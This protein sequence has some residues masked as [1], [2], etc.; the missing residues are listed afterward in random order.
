VTGP[1]WKEPETTSWS[2][3]VGGAGADP[4]V[5]L[6]GRG[7]AISVIFGNQ[8]L[9]RVHYRKRDE[10]FFTTLLWQKMDGKWP[11]IANGVF[12]IVQNHGEKNYFRR[13]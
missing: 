2:G 6:G 1:H 9:L 10:V 12:R 13:F 8:V 7:G 4:L 3:T 5:S 11:Y